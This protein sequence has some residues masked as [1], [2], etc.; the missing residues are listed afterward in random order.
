MSDIG[1]ALGTRKKVPAETIGRIF[2][3]QPGLLGAVKANHPAAELSKII[4]IYSKGYLA[5]KNLLGNASLVNLSHLVS[6]ELNNARGL[7]HKLGIR[8]VT[9]AP[10]INVGHFL[11]VVPGKLEANGV[12]FSANAVLQANTSVIVAS[13]LD[14]TQTTLTIQPSVKK[15]TIIVETLTCGR[16]AAIT[17]DDSS[18]W[19]PTSLPQTTAP[20]GSSYNP[21]NQV[22]HTINGPNGGDGAH[23]QPGRPQIIV[24]PAAPSV[25]IYAL[26]I[27]ALPT[28][29]LQGLKGA[30]G[31]PGQ[32][33]GAGGTGAKGINGSDVGGL[34][35]GIC[36]Q[37]PGNGGNGGNGGAGGN[38]GN[39][40]DG[41]HGGNVAIATTET[42][43]KSLINKGA[44]LLFVNAG[45]PGGDPGLP[46]HGGPG[47]RGGNG[48]N[49]SPG[50]CCNNGHNGKNGGPGKK[51]ANGH[52]G[53]AGHD[54]S[55][56]TIKP[57]F[58]TQQEWE[59]EL[60]LPWL[61]TIRPTVGYAGATV[62][63]SGMNFGPGDTVLVNGATAAATFPANDQFNV[64]LPD[65]LPGGPNTIAVRR[66]SDKV[67]S[68]TMTFT[69]LP[70]ISGSS[71]GGGYAPGD[72]ITITGSGFLTNA[73]VHLTQPGQS[74][75]V[76]VPIS[77]TPTSVKFQV[78][79]AK[80]NSSFPQANA[81]VVVANPNGLH[82]N[83]LQIT[84]LSCLVNGFV[85]SVHGFQFTNLSACPGL[86]SLS[87]F[88]S[89]FG[90]GEVAFSFLTN[91]V[92]TAAYYA[93]YAILL[94]PAC[95]GLCT[96]LAG[97]AVDRFSRGI[98]DV[99]STFPTA[100]T[101]LRTEFTITWA[102]QLSGELLASFLEQC[103]NGDSQ[104]MTTL[105]YI[106]KAFGDL[107]LPMGELPLVFLIPSG[108]P[109]SIKWL[110][111]IA[112]SHT[113]VPYK[114]VRPL[115]WTSGY[116]GV[117]LYLYDCNAPGND[118]SFITFKQDGSTVTFD[119]ADGGGADYH[120]RYSSADKFTLGVQSM[121]D[122]VYRGVDLPWMTG[123]GWVLEFVLSPATLTVSNLAGQITGISGEKLVSQLPGVVP[124]LFGSEHNLVMIP[125][126]LALKRTIQGTGSG[127]Y[128]YASIAPPKAPA[129]ALSSLLPQGA[130]AVVP[131][132]RGFTLRNVPCTKSTKDVVLV[133]P[134]NQSIQIGT[135]DSKKT[136]DVLI[137]QHYEVQSGSA[138]NQTTTHQMQLV[139]LNGLTLNAGEELLLWTDAAMGQV[140]ISNPGAAKNFTVTVSS[141]DASSKNPTATHTVAG[142]VAANAD[143]R[144]MI[145]D[146]KLADAPSTE[147]GKLRKLLPANFQMPTVK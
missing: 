90:T 83:T 57:S 110:E 123:D 119:Y 78:P 129:S 111:N 40:G 14:L 32:N 17:Y 117:K 134:D 103:Q 89:D 56:G 64:T 59:E 72:T 122:A 109:V 68:D 147:K 100:T 136:F 74:E 116:D 12:S 127:T 84:R 121:N 70:F 15:L 114:L 24:P 50:G 76:L 92:L 1:H 77:V 96:G 73:S 53:K 31:N 47:G 80:K 139:H 9:E 55:A 125:P 45:G 86:P 10:A 49:S 38:G 54:G 33:G 69:V 16:G 61:N 39:G 118:E 75:Q 36:N 105:Q 107:N 67:V 7:M 20:R 2:E 141:L 35:I 44:N 37:S 133:G 8:N 27:S 28:F 5:Q 135:N 145:P 142:S 25:E 63:G 138:P 99:Y 131:R 124:S 48:G 130:T 46:G 34:G 19:H 115:G 22:A 11:R 93:L 41:G 4:P 30:P 3:L 140:G 26:N 52:K 51:G 94:G 113:L 65:N 43:W 106:E 98:T 6:M 128:S 91:P 102:R 104:V 23:G 112:V 95:Q 81:T 60:T 146:W 66:A 126:Q 143:F 79:S 13:T 85:P 58:I 88:A 108:L 87:T 21:A 29:N 82:S 71:A 132:E 18:V 97:G 120:P 137:A 42:Q 101:T 144:M 62:T